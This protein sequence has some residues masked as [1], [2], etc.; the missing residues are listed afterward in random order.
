[1]RGIAQPSEEGG[2]QSIRWRWWIRFS[3]RPSEEDAIK[4]RVS[5]LDVIKGVKPVYVR[6]HY[7][8]EKP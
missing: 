1:M 5:H 7:V 8:F 3:A 2:E 6:N 4:D